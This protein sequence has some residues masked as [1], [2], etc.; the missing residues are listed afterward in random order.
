[1]KRIVLTGGVLGAALALAACGQKSETTIAEA[2]VAI[3]HMA[4]KNTSVATVQ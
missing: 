2:P 3:C 1:M 4:I